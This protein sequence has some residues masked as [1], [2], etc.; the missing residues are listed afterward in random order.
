MILNLNP[1]IIFLK[2]FL[3]SSKCKKFIE[4]YDNKLQRSFVVDNKKNIVNPERTSKSKLLDNKDKNIQKLLLKISKVLKIPE[5]NCEPVVFTKYNIDEEYKPHFDAFKEPSKNNQ[6]THTA[7]LYLSKFDGGETYFDNLDLKINSE[8]GS[9]CIFENCFFD[10]DHI[11][12]GSL[13]SGLKVNKGVKFIMTF[14][15]RRHRF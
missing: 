5:E 6:R 11:N 13:H 14:W 12:P 1:K 4:I 7:I 2:D 15:F 10:T 8:I 9:I 3:Q